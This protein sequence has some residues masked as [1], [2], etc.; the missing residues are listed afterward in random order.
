MFL[1]RNIARSFFATKGFRNLSGQTSNIYTLMKFKFL[2]TL[3][4][5]ICLGRAVHAQK[6][7]VAET[8]YKAGVADYNQ[9]RYAVAMEKLSPLTIANPDVSYATVAPYAHYYYSLSAYQL[10]RYRES[11]Q[12]LLQ[13]VSRY[14]GWTKINEAYYLLGANNF[15]TGQNKEAV[16][17]LLKIKDSSLAKDV[18]TLKQYHLSQLNDQAKLREI[19][20]L[21]PNDRDVAVVLVQIIENSKSSSKTDLQFASQL[22]KQFRISRSEKAA[23]VEDSP[24]TTIPKSENQW[25]KGYFDVSVLLPFRLEEFSTSKRRTNQFAY[26]YYLGLTLAKEKLRSEGVNVNLWA[27]DISN[28]TKPMND[29]VANTAFQKSD[30]V[31]GPLYTGTFDVTADAVSGSGMLMLNPLSTDASLLK[32][33]TNIYLAHPGIP[34]Q[35]QRAAQWMKVAAPGPQ[36]AVYYGSNAKDSMMAFSYAEEWKAKGGKVIEMLKIRAE[37]EWLESKIGTFEV[38]KPSHVALF[39]T[40]VSTGAILIDV[41]N[42]RKLITTPI[43]ATSTSFNMQQSRVGKYGARLYLIEADY[44]DRYK[45]GIREFQ[46]T[47]WNATNTF[48]SVYSY[49]GYDQLL[50]FGRMLN[51]YKDGV[52]RGIQSRKHVDEDYLLSGFDFTKSNDNHISP[53][54]R[55]SGGGKWVPV[56]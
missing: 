33:G 35:I 30:L 55:Y 13:L 44:V 5:I 7:T 22:E 43:I 41:L 48:P 8:E 9:Q 6:T 46:K 45:E 2:I 15:A 31:I 51:Q 16:D 17:F 12:M 10:K 26:D 23:V 3:I 20:K 34:Y 25:K 53:I 1:N 38:N 32:A 49:Q 39:S 21:Y 47:Y 18:Q 37:R 54:L 27:Y 42:G 28:D 52:Q 4:I 56:N 24:K 40:D 11:K 29:V 50:F 36:A 19:Q 14:P